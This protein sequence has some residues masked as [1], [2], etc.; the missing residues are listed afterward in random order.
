MSRY[1]YRK[2]AVG[3]RSKKPGISEIVTETAIFKVHRI[4]SSCETRISNVHELDWLPC[5]GI[6]RHWSRDGGTYCKQ[7]F[8]VMRRQIDRGVSYD[9]IYHRRRLSRGLR[10]LNQGTRRDTQI[11]LEKTC[12]SE[13]ESMMRWYH[14]YHHDWFSREGMLPSE[15]WYE[16]WSLA[17]SVGYFEHIGA[18]DAAIY[19][20]M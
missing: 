12:A 17:M 19:I 3:I 14:H 18:V 4:T 15:W 10:E 7:C 1:Q 6:G 20:V 16:V 2:N 5:R 13:L 8:R 9:W 11:H